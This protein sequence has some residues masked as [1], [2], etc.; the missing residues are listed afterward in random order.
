MRILAINSVPYGSTAK[1]MIGIG[2]CCENSQSDIKYYTATGFSTHPLKEMPA[3]NILIGSAFS[4]LLHMLLSKLTGYNGYCSILSTYLFL[5]KVD[6]IK[7]DCIHLHNI[8][9]WYINIPMLFNYI[10]KNSIPTIWTLHDSWAFTGQC[11][12]FTMVECDKWKEGCYK[13]IQY[14]RCYPSSLI[15]N[16]KRM[17]MKK[18]EWFQGVKNL[19]IVTPSKW[20]STMVKESFL[21]DY[22]ITVIYNGIDLSKF[23]P[24]NSSIKE[25]LDVKPEQ[26]IVLGVALDWTIYKGVDV[27]ERLSRELDSNYYKIILVGCNDEVAKKIP[28][29]IHVI[30][31]T[32]S[33]EELAAIYSAADVF[34][35]PTREEVLGLTNI[36]ALACGTPVISFNTGGC[37]ETY[38][39]YTGITV[40]RD[41]VSDLIKAINSICKD[42]SIKQK[43]IERATQFDEAE[44]YQD[45]I[46]LYNTLEGNI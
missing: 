40:E 2:K 8:H 39:S 18:K 35:N 29:N 23:K 14:N 4:K 9:G 3:N 41:N 30:K 6:K 43:C 10:K 34:V 33:Q 46:K 20:L 16:T 22:P 19:T 21:K 5:K 27:F 15:D 31:R 24:T 17:W 36:E 45:Y 11:P 12:Y 32:E 1:I 44:K 42:E 13:C 7:P 26:K 25:K 37:P 28:A 38:D